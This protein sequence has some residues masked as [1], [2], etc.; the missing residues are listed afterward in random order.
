MEILEPGA[1]IYGDFVD[2][3]EYVVP[4]LLVFCLDLRWERITDLYLCSLLQRCVLHAH[5][6]LLLHPQAQARDPRPVYWRSK[7][8]LL[9]QPRR[10]LA[11]NLCSP[12]LYVAFYAQVPLPLYLLHSKLI[13]TAGLVNVVSGKQMAPAVLMRMFQINYIIGAPIAFILFYN[14]SYSGRYG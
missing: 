1:D 6:R 9:V 7:V 14:I 4:F 13:R 10:E 8:H 2:C 11:R 3:V 5:R 12:L